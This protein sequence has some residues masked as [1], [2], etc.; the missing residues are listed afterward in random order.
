MTHDRLCGIMLCLENWARYT[1]LP[2]D[3]FVSCWRQSAPNAHKAHGVQGVAGSN[4]AVPT[5]DY[6]GL[7]RRRIWRLFSFLATDVATK[8]AISLLRKSSAGIAGSAGSV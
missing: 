2:R 7:S 8:A 4:P 5:T 1:S 3:P 6:K